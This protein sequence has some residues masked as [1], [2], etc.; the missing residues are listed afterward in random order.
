MGPRSSSIT[1]PALP[2]D[3]EDV[4]QALSTA[5]MLWQ[6]GAWDDAIRWIRRAAAL[7]AERDNDDRSLELFQAA[8]SLSSSV[9]PAR[10]SSSNPPSGLRVRDSLV[11]D[12]GEERPPVPANENMGVS[13]EPP[14][15][16]LP[17]PP[18]APKGPPPLNRWVRAS[19]PCRRVAVLPGSH[20]GE[21]RVVPLAFGATPPVGGAVAMLLPLSEDD[22]RA[23]SRVISTRPPAAPEGGEPDRDG[24]SD[25]DEG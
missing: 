24:R 3:P 20:A 16:F 25:D 11:A 8:M 19:L 5:A 12:G 21:V 7:L 6:R 14:P 17:P 10:R 2:D 18:P 13:N 15:P 1:P 22:A 9:A 4:N 23:L